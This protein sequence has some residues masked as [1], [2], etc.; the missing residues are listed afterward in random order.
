M[1]NAL[2]VTAPSPEYSN[3]GLT[4][5]F[6]LFLLFQI[7]FDIKYGFFNVYF[8]LCQYYFSVNSVGKHS[9]DRVHCQHIY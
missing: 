3:F 7:I 5:F 9:S 6:S 1:T 8:L 2:T 4:T